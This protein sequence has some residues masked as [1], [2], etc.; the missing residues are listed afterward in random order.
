MMPGAEPPSR[1]DGVER[2]SLDLSRPPPPPAADDK[3]ASFMQS[4]FWGRF[5]RLTGWKAYSCVIGGARGD[6]NGEILALV[7]P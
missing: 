2:I 5:K 7:R 4:G 1:F 3:P 6:G